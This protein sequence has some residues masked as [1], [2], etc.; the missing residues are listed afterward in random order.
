MYDP[1]AVL[2]AVDTHTI[3]VLVLAG[4][5]VI[6]MTIWFAEAF[7]MG[8]RD[9]T[10]AFPIF[11]TAFWFA[12]DTSY[13]VRFDQWFTTYD[14]WFLELFWFALVGTTLMEV[15]Y[16][17][18]TLR[19]G[20]GD[21]SLRLSQ[22]AYIVVFVGALISGFVLWSMVKATF[23]D[24]LYLI[25]FGLTVAIFPPFG[26]ALTLRRQSISGQSALMWVGYTILDF[27]WFTLTT[28][29][30]GPAFHSWQWI[31][32]GVFGALGGCAGIWL[33]VAG[34]R[35]GLVSERDSAQETSAAIVGPLADLPL[36]PDTST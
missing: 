1:N 19:Y 15:L 18:Q 17:R 34:A 14:H 21:L 4:V 27:G 5:T 31:G 11:C 16:I 22:R 36:T 26:I 30:F 25:A 32:L 29:Y 35:Y 20:R 8:R 7:R 12:H 33:M 24:D 10:Y 23:D 13:V 3:G 6:G 9:K 2:A 28:T